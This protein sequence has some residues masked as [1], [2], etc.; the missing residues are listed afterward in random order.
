MPASGT[1]EKPIGPNPYRI[2]LSPHKRR[3]GQIRRLIDAI[4]DAPVVTSP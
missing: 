3:Y 1:Y 4:N 2:M